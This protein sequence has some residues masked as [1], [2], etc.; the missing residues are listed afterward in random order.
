MINKKNIIALPLL[1]AG[2][3][4]TPSTFFLTRNSHFLLALVVI[5]LAVLIAYSLSMPLKRSFLSLTISFVFGVGLSAILSLIYWKFANNFESYGL[6]FYL[7]ISAVEFGITSLIGV[8]LITI[9]KTL[10]NIK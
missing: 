5:C 2:L 7:Y 3:S 8:I 6:N 1:L 10:S 9:I 4:T